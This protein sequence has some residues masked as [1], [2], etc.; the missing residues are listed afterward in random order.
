MDTKKHKSFASSGLR[1][2]H[3]YFVISS[4]VFLLVGFLH[5]LRAF[6]GWELLV[7]DITV[8]N[9]V[10]WFAVFVAGYMAY[11]GFKYSKK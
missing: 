2:E 6:Y 3:D 7:G 10:S 5:F 8:P 11:T 9:V 1:G 4:G